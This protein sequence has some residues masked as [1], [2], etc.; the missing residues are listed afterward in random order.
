M[1]K[2]ACDCRRMLVVPETGAP[3]TG[4]NHVSFCERCGLFYVT[5]T[6]RGVTTCSTFKLSARHLKVLAKTL[7]P[8]AKT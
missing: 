3:P 1:V 6:T 5:R 8:E 7:A 2:P 4:A